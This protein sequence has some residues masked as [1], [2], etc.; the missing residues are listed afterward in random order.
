MLAF[1]HM[2]LHAV[3]FDLGGVVLE[4]PIEHFRVHEGRLGLP[5]HFISKLVV[6]SG[7][8]E[9]WARLERGE[10]TMA[11]FYASFDAEARAAGVDLSAADLMAEIAEVSV[12][13]PAML[14]AVRRVRTRGLKV[15]A[16]TNNWRG[17]DAQTERADALKSEFDVFVE[18]C[19]VGMRKP[20][21]RIYRYACDALAV[22]PEHV[23]F[24][25]DIGANLKP[26]RAMGMVTIKVG[27]AEAAIDELERVLESAG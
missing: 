7:D 23:V 13:R 25:D 11:D 6:G 22:Q 17:E 9:A 12:V 5:R 14:A 2:Q 16:L 27:K 10:L 26:A 21:E 24:L 19:R 15:A 8:D 20:E 1:R 3:M 18:S 4:S